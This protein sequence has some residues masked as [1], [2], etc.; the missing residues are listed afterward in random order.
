MLSAAA[1]TTDPANVLVELI[2]HDLP[3]VPESEDFTETKRRYV[4]QQ[5]LYNAA[6]DI[7]LEA[8]SDDED[9]S[10]GAGDK[11]TFWEPLSRLLISAETRHQLSPGGHTGDERSKNGDK[12]EA[13]TLLG[14]DKEQWDALEHRR[15]VQQVPDEL[16]QMLL[17][18]VEQ[19]LST[20]CQ[21]LSRSLYGKQSA[22]PKLDAAKARQLCARV[23][24]QKRRIAEK[25]KEALTLRVR[26][27]LECDLYLN[28]WAK[29][30]DTLWRLVA[31]YKC[32]VEPEKQATFMEYFAAIVK[33]ASLKMRCLKA[34]IILA[35]STGPQGDDLK[36]TRATLLQTRTTLTTRLHHLDAQLATYAGV[37]TGDEFSRIVSA[38]ADVMRAIGTVEGDI[39]R[40]GGGG[41][42][43]GSRGR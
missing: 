7:L 2:T 15:A 27:A 17:S 4:E 43:G 24:A 23:I 1:P 39:G 37:G 31:D 35:I 12:E 25:K 32:R 10:L 42:V 22:D 26:I 5:I 30:I 6:T 28:T 29:T 16:R 34:E 19:R 21:T 41:G 3:T 11:A 36:A 13:P 14:M 33:N 40:L 9:A 18:K 20:T 8:D 38:Y